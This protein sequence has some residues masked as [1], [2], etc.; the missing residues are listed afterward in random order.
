[1]SCVLT[2]MDPHKPKLAEE[3]REAKSKGNRDRWKMLDGE[4]VKSARLDKNQYFEQKC[5]Q[6]D[7][8]VAKSSKK[9]FQV[10]REGT[11]K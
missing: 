3:R 8:E 9:V 10:I 5:D 2:R 4:V 1:M 11:G 7:N 6:M